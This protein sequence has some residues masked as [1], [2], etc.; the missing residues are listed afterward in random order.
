MIETL[1]EH[2]IIELDDEYSSLKAK[3]AKHMARD[4]MGSRL[5]QKWIAQ[6]NRKI[7]DEIFQNVSLF[8]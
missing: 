6:N 1:K 7:I 4:Q 5:L 8:I 3:N 2:I